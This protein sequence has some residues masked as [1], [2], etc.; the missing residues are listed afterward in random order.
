MIPGNEFGALGGF[1]DLAPAL[2]AA[3]AGIIIAPPDSGEGALPTT[4]P[5]PN[6][7]R[8]HPTDGCRDRDDEDAAMEEGGPPPVPA[9]FIRENDTDGT[10]PSECREE[11]FDSIADA[12]IGT[13]ITCWCWCCLC[14]CC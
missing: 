6:V 10:V 14:W 11:M 5:P 8:G 4:V 9:S 3:V 2:A 7:S 1:A 13:G 12:G